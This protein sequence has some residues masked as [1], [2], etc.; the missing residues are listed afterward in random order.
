M[1]DIAISKLMSRASQKMF[2]NKKRF[3]VNE[4]HGVLKLVSKSECA[5][6]LVV[7]ASCPESGGERLIKQP[8]VTEQVNRG[9]RGFHGHGAGVAITVCPYF[10]HRV[11]GGLG[12]SKAKDDFAL[13][14]D[15]TPRA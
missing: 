5:S 9:I 1:L 13:G 2:A 6:W 15:S 11:T 12:P 10:F 8:A 14:I 4:S 3:G 7:A